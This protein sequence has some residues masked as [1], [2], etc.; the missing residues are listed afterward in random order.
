[1]KKTAPNISATSAP[2]PRWPAV[3]SPA[4]PSQSGKSCF[5]PF[6]APIVARALLVVAVPDA[7]FIQQTD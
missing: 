3:I 2:A 1:M 7:A 4:N 6:Q 5:Q